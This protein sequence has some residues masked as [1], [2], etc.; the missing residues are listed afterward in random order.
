MDIDKFLK[1]LSEL[2]RIQIPSQI[3]INKAMD[4]INSQI[5]SQVAISKAMDRINSQLPPTQKIID[6]YQKY[7]HPITLALPSNYQTDIQK[8]SPEISL[9]S[10]M[11][12]STIP[13]LSAY[14]YNLEDF[15]EESDVEEKIEL[16]DN[17]KLLLKNIYSQNKLLDIVD[18][19]EFEKIVAELLYFKGYEVHLTKRTRDGGYDVLALTKIGGIPFKILA[20]CKRHKRTIGI[21]IIRSFCDVVNYEKANKGLIF[22]TSYFSQPAINR[23]AEMGT[24]LDLKNRDDLIEWIIQ[25]NNC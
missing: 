4:R 1:K 18:P 19:R 13:D 10:K 20:E 7:Y 25:Y 22:T 12:K 21:D 17:T 14:Q 23:Q 3:A 2:Q 15:Q 9:I 24:I 11:L 8:I 6:D 16:I 5:P